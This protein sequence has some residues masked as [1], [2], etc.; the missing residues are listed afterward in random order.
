VYLSGLGFKRPRLS[1]F[2]KFPNQHMLVDYDLSWAC[3]IITKNLSKDYLFI[4][5]AHLEN[6]LTFEFNHE[7]PWIM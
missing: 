3:V 4:L 7:C 1:G 5:L 2:H 6:I